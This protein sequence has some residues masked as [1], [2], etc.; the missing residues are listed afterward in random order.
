M[1]Q[2]DVVDLGRWHSLAMEIEVGDDGVV[3]VAIHRQLAH[4]YIQYAVWALSI[5][6]IIHMAT[7]KH[8][9]TLERA[10]SHTKVR[11]PQL[12]NCLFLLL[13][14]ENVN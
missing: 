12:L 11:H 6:R 5:F 9:M 8:R 2:I 3:G 1:T 10:T 7:S 13:P 14:W 4:H